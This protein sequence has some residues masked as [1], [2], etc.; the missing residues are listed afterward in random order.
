MHIFTL[1]TCYSTM[2]Y[3]YV[4]KLSLYNSSIGVPLKYVIHYNTVYYLSFC[5]FLG[6]NMM[7]HNARQI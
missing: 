5:S 6:V 7:N 3:K 1:N 2:M 4:V